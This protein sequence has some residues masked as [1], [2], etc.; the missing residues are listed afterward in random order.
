MGGGLLSSR[1]SKMS[2]KLELQETALKLDISISVDDKEL[3]IA[4]LEQA[5]AAHEANTDVTGPNAEMLMEPVSVDPLPHLI[6]GLTVKDA[7]RALSKKHGYPIN[8]PD[9]KAYRTKISF[10][11]ALGGGLRLAET[12]VILTALNARHKKDW[13]TPV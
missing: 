10:N 13:I 2:R 11:C 6:L 9:G 5:I 4:E 12:V 7:D 1:E 3:T 8:V